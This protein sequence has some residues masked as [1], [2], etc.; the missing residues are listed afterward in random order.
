[1][2]E[3]SSIA[4]SMTPAALLAALDHIQPE[5]PDLLGEAAW[6][7]E[8]EALLGQIEALRA[9][10][11]AD[12]SRRLA[13]EVVKSVA[14]HPD[15]RARLNRELLLLADLRRSVAPE[16]QGL[17]A[18]LG[19]SPAAADRALAAADRALAAALKLLTIQQAAPD[20]SQGV[21][22]TLYTG[23]GGIDGGT[24]V[25]LRHL[26]FDAGELAELLAGLVLTGADVF[27]QP[28]PLVVVAGLIQVVRSLQ[29][30]LSVEVDEELT[31][32]YWGLFHACGRPDRCARLH[33]IQET[34]NTT[35]ARYGRIALG[36]DS[37]RQALALLVDL[38]LAEPCPSEADAWRFLERI[39]L[40]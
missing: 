15:A 40:A 19:L 29:K 14:R 22:R 32:V 5:L 26:Q 20:E 11:D 35:R 4:A 10:Q 6:Q 33:E 16:L 30:I 31:T 9:S 12:A 25:R 34:V 28:H 8:G 13:V 7:A 21:T 23:P 17:A 27:G 37:V 2:A 38:R 39:E 24:V 36:E 1:M 3:R 18:G